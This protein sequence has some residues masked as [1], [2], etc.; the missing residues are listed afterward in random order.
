MMS[1]FPDVFIDVYMPIAG[2]KAR[3][4]VV[5]E[6]CDGMHTPWS[7]SPFA[8]AYKHQAVEYA[9]RWARDEEV[10]YIDTCP[11]HNDP[12]PDKSVAE[13]IQEII[14]G[15]TFIDLS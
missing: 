4:M 6:D 13:Q 5:D 9:Q 12:A 10:P 7:T 11:D 15:I 1:E 3:M 14:P 8:W 2:W